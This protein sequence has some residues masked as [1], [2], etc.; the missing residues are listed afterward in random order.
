MSYQETEE[1]LY[2]AITNTVK[3]VEKGSNYRVKATALRDLAAAFRHV[4]GGPQPGQTHVEVDV[5]K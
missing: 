1:A 2:T 4:T 3:E 5:H